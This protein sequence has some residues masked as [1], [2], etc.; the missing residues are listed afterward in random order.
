MNKVLALI[1]GVLIVGGLGWLVISTRNGKYPEQSRPQ[2]EAEQAPNF[3]LQNYDGQTIQ[4]ADFDGRPVVINSWAAWC[5]FCGKELVDFVAVQKEFGNDVVIV[6]VDRAES[7]ET[8]K[9]YTDELGVTK[10]L[11][12]LLD[13][14]DSFYQSIGGFSMPETIFIDKNGRIVDH[15]HGPMDVQEM[16]ERIQ[17]I[18]SE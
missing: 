11:I 13:P 16:R 3:A 2:A 9:K 5:P 18:L 6:A 10:N 15:K 8:A 14:S 17:K 7:Q 1:I 4:L 12:F